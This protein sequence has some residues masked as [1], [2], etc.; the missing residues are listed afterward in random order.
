MGEWLS[1]AVAVLGALMGGSGLYALLRVGAEREKVEAEAARIRE[2]TEAFAKKSDIESLI[3]VVQAQRLRMEMQDRKIAEQSKRID[4]LE[5]ENARLCA[6]LKQHGIDPNC[7]V[8][9]ERVQGG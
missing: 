8:N 9:G 5:R 7:V 4:Y 1:F 2:E 6:V 3:T